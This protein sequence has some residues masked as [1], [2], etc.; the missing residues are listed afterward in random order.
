IYNP[1]AGRFPA[2]PLLDRAAMVLGQAGWELQV[3][4]ASSGEKL[5]DL[6]RAAVAQGC[7]AVF[8]AGGDGSVGRVASALAG[9]ETALGVLP[10]G[11]ANVWA[12]ELGL[13]R[14]DWLNLFALEDAAQMLA[15]AQVRMMDLGECNGRKFLLWAG[16]GIDGRVVKVLEPRDR[17][18]K[19]LGGINYATQVVWK[20]LDWSG[21]QLRVHA[22]GRDWE[23]RCIVGVASNIRAYAG[24]L[25]ELAQEARVD[26]GLL[27]FWLISG[28]SLID[29]VYRTVQV[30]LGAHTEDPGIAH[31]QAGEATFESDVLS[32]PM[33]VD[34]EPIEMQTPLHFQVHPKA[35]RVLV[36]EALQPRV[37]SRGDVPAGTS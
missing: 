20:S 15:Q 1:A 29:V 7:T 23:E 31:F 30:L 12:K 26:D 8:V 27:D 35:L 36:P 6:A 24:G 28:R 2:G 18:E 13:P 22:S 37:F 5:T 19:A 9:T 25:F 14:L 11:T 4:E 33:H 34:G 16:M 17:W 32:L 10:A 21:I 3:V